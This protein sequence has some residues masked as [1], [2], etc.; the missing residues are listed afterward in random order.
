MR[1]AGGA[2]SKTCCC[3]ASGPSTE[4]KR[5]C[6]GCG[7]QAWLNTSAPPP[8]S[9]RG[10]AAWDPARESPTPAQSL[11]DPSSNG[12]ASWAPWGSMAAGGFSTFEIDDAS[13]AHEHGT[14]YRRNHDRR[15]IQP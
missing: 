1:G 2:P 5:K 3:E 12:L 13:C 7:W 14:P 4:S 9:L 15:R 10:A 11:P 8:A 6:L